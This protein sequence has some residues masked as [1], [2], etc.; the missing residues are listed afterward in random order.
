MWVGFFRKKLPIAEPLWRRRCS[1]G[2]VL[3]CLKNEPSATFFIDKNKRQQKWSKMGF[4][5]TSKTAKHQY[6]LL[7]KSL[8]RLRQVRDAF[9]FNVCVIF[10]LLQDKLMLQSNWRKGKK[11]LIHVRLE[12]SLLCLFYHVITYITNVI[13]NKTCI[14]FVQLQNSI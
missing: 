3:A 11:V 4:T 7:E 2:I 14:W 12:H 10:V 13:T 9:F 1:G 6:L 5:L 8:K